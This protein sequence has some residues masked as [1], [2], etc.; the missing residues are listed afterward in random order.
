[1]ALGAAAAFRGELRHPSFAVADAAASKARMLS[2]TSSAA[3]SSYDASLRLPNGFSPSDVGVSVTVHA[4]AGPQR[5]RRVALDAPISRQ[6]IRGYVRRTLIGT[7]ITPT[8]ASGRRLRRVLALEAGNRWN[9]TVSLDHTE[10]SCSAPADL[11]RFQNPAPCRSRGRTPEYWLHPRWRL[12][13]EYTGT[14]IS[15]SSEVDR[16]YER[17]T[18][19]PSGRA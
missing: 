3:G 16:H 13:D 5:V 8:S 9:G 15:N 18:R 10:A 6:R 2:A 1:M 7:T 17:L 4:V 14:F 19:T 11:R 12:T